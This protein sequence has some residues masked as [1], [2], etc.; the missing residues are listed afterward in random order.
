MKKLAGDCSG[1]R[2]AKEVIPAVI[3]GL[4]RMIGEE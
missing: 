4:A 1:E 2:M 3:C